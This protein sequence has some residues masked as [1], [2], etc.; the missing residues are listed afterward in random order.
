[1]HTVAVRWTATARV[2]LA[3]RA[4]AKRP[5]A[6][7][8]GRRMIASTEVSARALPCAPAARR[9]LPRTVRAPACTRS[10]RSSSRGSSPSGRG[11]L[12]CG[13]IA[14]QLLGRAARSVARRVRLNAPAFGE[15]PRVDR[16]EAELIEELRHGALGRG[17]VA[18]DHERPTIGCAA[19]L[20]VRGELGG[21][22]VVEGFD[23]LRAW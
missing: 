4:F 22:N 19:R 20:A 10:D 5:R 11:S 1:M 16:I 18:R 23:H 8:A 9:V 13:E 17:V 21:I 3:S 2:A 15:R 12:G 7:A 14:P 6:P